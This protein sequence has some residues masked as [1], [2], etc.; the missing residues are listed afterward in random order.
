MGAQDSKSKEII[1]EA[2]TKIVKGSY[3]DRYKNEIKDPKE[4]YDMNLDI[5]SFSRRPEI[6]WKIQTNS[7]KNNNEE[8]NFEMLKNKKDNNQ[9]I[10]DQMI[11]VPLEEKQEQKQPKEEVD[12][13]N[14]TEDDCLVL[15][16]V[17]LGNVGKSYLL[18]LFINQELPSGESIHTKGISVKII[19]DAKKLI[20]LDSEGV[21]A[22]LTKSNISKDLYPKDGDLLNKDI[23]ESDS[24][25]QTLAKDK[26]TVE[27]FIQD[28]IIDKS[29]ILFIVVG[30]I[31]FTEQK[32]IN[33]IVNETN[34]KTI[35]VI[36]N[37]KNFY[38]KEQINNYIEN[39]FKKNIFLNFETFSEQT[40]DKGI[41]DNVGNIEEFG[42]YFLEK[43]KINE[44][45]E[46]EVVH[47]IMGSNVKESEAFYFNKTVVEY[48]RKEIS[49]ING[50][51]KFNIIEELK[52][53]VL[54]KAQKYV[55]LKDNDATK[56]PFLEE[57]IKL[58]KE[59]DT[60]SLKIKNEANLKKCL[61]NPLGFSSFYGSLYSPNYICYIDE[62]VK[63]KDK[64]KEKE[65]KKENE[66]E[67]EKEKEKKFV[68][69][70]NLCGKE[71]ENYEVNIPKRE[72]I[73][74]EGQKTLI[75][76]S[77]TKKL[78]EYNNME[79]IDDNTSTMDSGNWKIHIVLD[80]N[81]YKIKQNTTVKKEKK[82]GIFRYI[83]TLENI[84][85]NNN[86]EMKALNFI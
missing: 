25:I 54:K 77:G 46:K 7:R 68:V 14:F 15:G 18:S 50:G 33:R 69:E 72:E 9:L 70:I 34:K 80:N 35:F 27:L 66:K 71:K 29:S 6:I 2:K 57:D 74:E 39:T 32:L 55:E 37:L 53:Y 10:P 38:N 85:H 24:L 56:P 4:F 44:H 30:Q 31:T 51:I 59:G 19:N 47:F 3:K 67:K 41:Q 78:K 48:V 1:N 82:K 17:G 65:D 75:I 42:K 61:I 62:S 13:D 86:S 81:K 40:Y 64:E 16:I 5:D 21:E 20:I 52:Q 36:H 76:I 84:E 79:V 26:K 73:S 45:L 22:P 63:E 12:I 58:E 43:Y 60:I 83:Y 49:S 23:N 11:E 28:F 8:Q